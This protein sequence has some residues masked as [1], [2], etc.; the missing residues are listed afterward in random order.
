M[1]QP[2]GVHRPPRI[3]A[4]LQ[5]RGPQRVPASFRAGPA[6]SVNDDSDESSSSDESVEIGED[7]REEI[8]RMRNR[9]MAEKGLPLYNAGKSYDEQQSRSR[10]KSRT[11]PPIPLYHET[12]SACK[13]TGFQRKPMVYETDSDSEDEGKVKSKL[14][15]KANIMLPSD[16]ISSGIQVVPKPEKTATK[17]EQKI[18]SPNMNMSYKKLR[19]NTAQKSECQIQ[20]TIQT[21]V[22]PPELN[23]APTLLAESSIINAKVKKSTTSPDSQ[24]ESKLADL[25]L[26]KTAS[27]KLPTN[28]DKSM[29]GNVSKT[30][31]EEQNETI[32]MPEIKHQ[33]VNITKTKIVEKNT[34]S[35]PNHGSIQISNE[36]PE[37]KIASTNLVPIEIAPI[38]LAPMKIASIKIA[39]PEVAPIKMAPTEIVP[40]KKAPSK[41]EI[42]PTKLKEDVKSIVNEVK[43]SKLQSQENP[44]SKEISKKEIVNKITPPIEPS[45]KK[46]TPSLKDTGNTDNSGNTDPSN[47]SRLQSIEIPENA[48]SSNL[49]LSNNK[50]IVTEHTEKV[51]DNCEKIPSATATHSDTKHSKAVTLQNVEVSVDCGKLE[52]NKS[53]IEK[54]LIASDLGHQIDGDNHHKL[55]NHLSEVVAIQ[56]DNNTQS[57]SIASADETRGDSATDQSKQSIKSKKK[58]KL[59]VPNETDFTPFDTTEDIF[60]IKSFECLFMWQWDVEN[61]TCAICRSSLME[62]SPTNPVCYCFRQKSFLILLRFRMKSL[63][64]NR[65]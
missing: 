55:P 3:P 51:T 1:K 28:K 44:I 39:P 48:Q 36:K 19:E 34:S 23:I 31:L 5:R 27:S 17:V 8:K 52:T 2:L 50:A 4:A 26:S 22:K 53:T 35:E 43:Q 16:K 42:A 46:A 25:S 56:P 11:P 38:E 33:K 29:N 13:Q 59:V 6:P 14:E 24:N 60:Q 61:E 18:N 7:A 64:M 15:N 45:Q 63:L 9:R 32:K 65:L 12:P 10:N 40:T 54:T 30:V 47:A 20:S 41:I 62:V 58:E 57:P 37:T 49:P 21:K